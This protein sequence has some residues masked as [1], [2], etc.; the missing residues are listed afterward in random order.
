[1]NMAQ[2]NPNMPKQKV[3]KDIWAYNG[4]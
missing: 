2:K 4:T 3:F 1:M